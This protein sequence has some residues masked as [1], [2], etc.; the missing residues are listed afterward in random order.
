MLRWLGVGELFRNRRDFFKLLCAVV[1]AGIVAN[2]LTLW[3]ARKQI[4]PWG[5]GLR[6]IGLLVASLGLV[7]RTD[8]SSLQET[9][10]VLRFIRLFQKGK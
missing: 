1:A 9:S 7:N 4:V 2:G 8:W 5:V 6:F 10:L 3:L